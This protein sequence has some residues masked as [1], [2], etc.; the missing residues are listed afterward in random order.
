VLK[1]V[2]L[3]WGPKDLSHLDLQQDLLLLRSL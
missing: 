1:P 3:N 2:G